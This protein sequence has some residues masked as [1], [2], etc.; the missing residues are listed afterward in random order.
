MQKID[1]ISLIGDIMVD[2]T[3]LLYQLQKIDSEIYSIEVKSQ[4]I[5]NDIKNDSIIKEAENIVE[6]ILAELTSCQK[7]SDELGTRIS[8][9]RNKVVQFTSSLF[10]G[11]IQNSKELNE[12]Q[13]EI[14]SLNKN[15]SVSEDQQ[16]EKWEELE[17]LQAKLHNAEEQ[18]LTIKKSCFV[19]NEVFQEK[20]SDYKKETGRLLVEKKGIHEQLSKVFVDLYERL[21]QT[22]KGTAVSIVEDSCCKCCGTTITPSD[23]QQAKNHSVLTFCKNC[24]RILYAG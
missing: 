23:C 13:S 17:V 10:G 18:L 21:L 6:N 15:I 22:K 3:F 9:F 20:L 16:M 1:I 11:K 8:T 4:K 14:A 12:L 24:G 7:V 19:Q 5:I 2:S